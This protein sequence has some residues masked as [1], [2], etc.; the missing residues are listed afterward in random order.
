[1]TTEKTMTQAVAEILTMERSVRKEYTYPR[2]ADEM[3]L[4]RSQVIRYFQGKSSPK[5]DELDALCRIL[6]LDMFD[7]MERARARQHPKG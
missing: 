3:G 2:I 6:G 5:I 7:V 1:M 4:S